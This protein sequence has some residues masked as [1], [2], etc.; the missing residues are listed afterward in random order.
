MTDFCHSSGHE[1]WPPGIVARRTAITA[2]QITSLDRE[3]TIRML[4]EEVLRALRDLG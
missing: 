2:W 3:T 4:G 1:Q